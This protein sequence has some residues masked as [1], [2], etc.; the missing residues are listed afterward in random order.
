M[1]D[2]VLLVRYDTTQNSYNL[3]LISLFFFE[4]STQ[5]EVNSDLLLRKYSIIVLDEAHERN[6]NTDILIGM[7]SKSIEL[8]RDKDCDLPPLRLIIMSAT[9]RIDDFQGVFP[10]KWC[11]ILIVNICGSTFLIYPS[12]HESDKNSRQDLPRHGSL[13]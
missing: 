4:L 13:Q 2:G 5:A 12:R 9:L 1:T 7:I 3:L 11:D 8:R 10:G 6:L